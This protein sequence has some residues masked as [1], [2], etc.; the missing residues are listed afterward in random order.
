MANRT[1]VA[2]TC[3]GAVPWGQF[4]SLLSPV[5]FTSKHQTQISSSGS[6]QE[7]PWGSATADQVARSSWNTTRCPLVHL[8]LQSYSTDKKARQTN[9]RV[10]SV[11]TS[12]CKAWQR[13]A[14]QTHA[15]AT[16]TVC[17]VILFL[18]I[19]YPLKYPL[20]QNTACPFTRQLPEKHHVSV[21]SKTSSYVSASAKRPLIR[22]FPEKHPMTQRDLQ[23]NQKFPLQWAFLCSYSNRCVSVS[24]VVSLQ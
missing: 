2:W 23:W 22:Q 12:I 7:K 24:C 3:L 10:S 15:S 16:S 4:Q 17:W 14:R 19:L 5:Q 18:S 21:L 8:S 20:Q 9:A 1:R 6:V 13:P 11:K